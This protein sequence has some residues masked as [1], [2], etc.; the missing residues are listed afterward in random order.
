MKKEYVKPEMVMEEILLE[1]M[2]AQSGELGG[3]GTDMGGGGVDRPGGGRPD[4]NE[5]RGGWGDLWN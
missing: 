1:G 2:L 3:G 4:A 5:H